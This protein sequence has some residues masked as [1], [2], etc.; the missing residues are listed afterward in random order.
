MRFKKGRNVDDLA[1]MMKVLLDTKVYNEAP[2]TS[3]DLYFEPKAWD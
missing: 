1:I 3:R 2:L